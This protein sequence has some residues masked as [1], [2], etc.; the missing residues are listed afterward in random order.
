M[1]SPVRI[2]IMNKRGRYSTADYSAEVR[3]AIGAISVALAKDGVKKKK[4]RAILENAGYDVPG[5]TLDNWMRAINSG[6]TP[7]K[8]VK[9]T[10]AKKKLTLTQRRIVAGWTIDQVG[11]NKEV[12]MAGA[13]RFIFQ[14]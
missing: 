4:I 1:I 8:R 9:L 14:S 12:H 6:Q 10:G 2:K 13:Q 3:S 7:L 5:T 11:Q